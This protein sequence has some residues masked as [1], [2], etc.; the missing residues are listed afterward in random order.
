M[1]IIRRPNFQNVPT[2]A[3]FQSRHPGNINIVHWWMRGKFWMV[4]ATVE[5]VVS[6]RRE[7]FQSILS[8]QNVELLMLEYYLS[9]PKSDNMTYAPG[10]SN[11]LPSSIPLCKPHKNP[12]QPEPR[13]AHRGI[14]H[15]LRR[16]DSP[17]L[18]MAQRL[19]ISNR[20]LELHVLAGGRVVGGKTFKACVGNIGTGI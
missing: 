6:S 10:A 2:R 19:V 14:G 18:R 9:N 20:K 3:C 13:F 15:T 1:H 17:T 12:V 5:L 8:T 4:T 7:N 11:N 16:I